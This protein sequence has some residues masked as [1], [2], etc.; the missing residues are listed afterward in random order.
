[1]H[2]NPIFRQTEEAKALAFARDRAF[3]ILAVSTEGAPLLAH[4][5]F[6]L[7]DDA[8]CAGLH[9]VRSNPICRLR[10]D[11]VPA[12]L[13]VSGP[14][15][16]I[17]PDWYGIDDQVPTWNYVAVALT[18]RLIT[19]PVEQ[20]ED[21]LAAQSAA[22]EARLPKPAWTMDKMTAGT[23]ARFL[24]MILPFR[25]EIDTIQSTWKLNQNKPDSARQAAA[26]RVTGGLGMDLDGLSGLMQ[27][28]NADS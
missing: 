20:L 7:P 10:R 11:S 1:M 26:N 6:L 23:R 25:F 13:E 24:R 16:Y 5:P 2:P 22:Y 12:R 9:L 18:G 19:Q 17:S 21:L 14:D 15:G 27:H 4:V 3:G 28:A 8:T